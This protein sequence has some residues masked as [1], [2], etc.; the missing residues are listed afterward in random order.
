M[1]RRLLV[2]YLIIEWVAVDT[3]PGGVAYFEGGNSDMS[4]GLGR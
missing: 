1:T 2:V 3:F 4:A